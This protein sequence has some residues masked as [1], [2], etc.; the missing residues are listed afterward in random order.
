MAEND[1]HE[2]RVSK[3]FDALHEGVG[4][5]LDEEARAS[6]EKLRA[7]AAEK[8]ADR[9]REHLG[10]VKE[11]HSWLYEEMA[12]HPDFAAL[13]NELAVWGF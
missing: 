3:A 7:A 9:L 12:A 2:D 8:D 11:R 13:V 6:M 1:S 4:D 5:R 10:E